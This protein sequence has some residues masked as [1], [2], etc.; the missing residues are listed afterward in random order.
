MFKVTNCL[1]CLNAI[2]QCLYSL[3]SHP[4]RNFNKT[5]TAAR[6]FHCKQL[7]GNVTELFACAIRTLSIVQLVA[8]YLS[9]LVATQNSY[10]DLWS[11]MG[12]KGIR[13][14]S[15]GTRSLQQISV[16]WPVICLDC[17]VFAVLIAQDLFK[18]FAVYWSFS[19]VVAEKKRCSGKVGKRTAMNIN[20]LLPENSEAE[21]SCELLPSLTVPVVG[22]CN[23][24][25]KTVALALI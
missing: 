13:K 23:F 10:H 19:V 5:F 9:V 20:Q 7:R 11:G 4:V 8:L 16:W 22:Y 21:T 18:E 1:L 24:K 15:L 2:A 6:M 14:R 17:R 3:L 25:L 12:Q